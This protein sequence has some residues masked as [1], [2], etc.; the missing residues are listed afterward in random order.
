[1]SFVRP[2]HGTITSYYGHRIHPVTGVR[3]TMHW[4]LDYGNTPH[5]NRIFSTA[6]GVVSAVGYVQGYGNRIIVSHT[7]NGQLYQSLYAHLSQYKCR[8]G[9]RVAAGETIAIKG[10]TGVST[11][12]HLHF[13]IHVGYH[14]YGFTNARN[15]AVFVYDEESKEIQ[16]RLRMLGYKVIPDGYYGQATHDAIKSFQRSKGL[17][18]DGFAG[19]NTRVALK[20][21]TP[22]YAKEIAKEKEQKEEVLIQ[23]DDTMAKFFNEGDSINLEVKQMLET[24]AGDGIIH[25]KWATQFEAGKLTGN[26]ILGLLTKVFNKR[27]NEFRPSTGTLKDE[28][29]IFIKRAIEDGVIKDEKWLKQAEAGTLSEDDLAAIQMAVA[30]REL[31]DEL[32]AKGEEK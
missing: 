30:N 18:V 24:A 15:P 27:H 8:V 29:V 23:E 12:I 9:Q 26:Q 2:C 1:M 6:A 19:Y 25:A 32:A 22:N 11:G 28:T 13:E 16:S 21:A 20:N 7:I 4:G 5:D 17:S 3:G 14:N 10:T 31:A